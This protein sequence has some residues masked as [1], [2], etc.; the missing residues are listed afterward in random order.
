MQ[1][2]DND[3]SLS[4]KFNTCPARLNSRASNK[5]DSSEYAATLPLARKQRT[6]DSDSD[7]LSVM[8]SDFFNA[9]LDT[10]LSDAPTTF[11]PIDS[12]QDQ[13][14]LQ[15]LG[16][17][18]D[19]LDMAIFSEGEAR[20]VVHS[21]H[22]LEPQLDAAAAPSAEEL[23]TLAMLEQ[24][25]DAELEPKQLDA[26]ELLLSM[27]PVDGSIEFAPQNSPAAVRPSPRDRA[28]SPDSL[29]TEA[30]LQLERQHVSS[31]DDGAAAAPAPAAAAGRGAPK[32][33][34]SLDRKEWT[35]AEDEVIRA[36]VAQ[37]GCKWRKIAAQ[38]P[39]RSDDSVRNRW[40][41]L[42]HEDGAPCAPPA[43]RRK[44]KK[45]ST[46][47]DDGPTPRAERVQWSKFEDATIVQ[48]V[49]ELGHKWYLIAQRL[50]G[51]T[52]HA[53]RNRYHRLQA[54]S[55]DQ[56]ILRGQYAAQQ[57]LHF[58]GAPPAPPVG[59]P[60]LSAVLGPVPEILA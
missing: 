45:D 26:G 36:S 51:R 17:L 33:R 31:F 41:R 16:D 1:F 25:A 3:L 30:T 42:K 11:G 60:N 12:A 23:E 57:G 58:D 37:W 19:G 47:D 44:S 39:G 6:C 55:E 50:P 20:E 46:S 9:P 10:P 2:L 32:E 5:R 35:A 13:I 28:N 53:I 4:Q 43:V 7:R 22:M 49:E 54:M 24:I 59:D 15:K 18:V 48:S 21:P 40:G 34:N 38:L 27:L 56:Q 14:N 8:S 52:D 29:L